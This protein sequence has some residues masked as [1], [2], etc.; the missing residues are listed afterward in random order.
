MQRLA[1][2]PSEKPGSKCQLGEKHTFPQPANLLFKGSSRLCEHARVPHERASTDHSLV[3]VSVQTGEN[4][5][6]EVISENTGFYD[7]SIHRHT[8]RSVTHETSPVLA[9]AT[10]TT[11]CLEPRAHV[12]YDDS[13]LPG[14]SSTMDNAGLLPTGCYAGSNFQ[15]ESGDHRCIQH[16]LRCNVQWTP[17]FQHL[18][19]CEKSV[20]HKLPRTT[21]CL[22]SIE[23]FSFRHCES[24]RSDLFGQHNS[25]GVHKSPLMEQASSPLTACDTCPRLPELRSGS[26]VTPRS[27]T[28]GMEISSADSD[29]DLGSIRQS[30]SQS[31]RHRGER[32]LSPLVLHVPSPTGRGGETQVCISLGA[33]PSFCHQQSPSG[34]GNSSVN[35]AKMAHSFLVS[36]DDRNTRWPTM[37]NIA[38]ERLPLSSK[39]HNL[40]SSARAVEPTHV[41]PE[42]STSDEPEL[43]QL[44]MNTILKAKALSTR[45]LNALKWHV[46][47]NWCSS[48][49]KDPVNC[50]IAEILTFLR[51]RLD[52]G[53][54][55]STL[56]VYV[57]T[58]SA[59]HTPE[60]GSLIGTH[61]LVI[62]FLWGARHLNPLALLW[63]QLGT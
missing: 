13:L 11:M 37:G 50:S 40:A 45:C 23:S 43:A 21:G 41:A 54:T 39:R 30:G 33:P 52:A 42:W 5:A 22:S 4:I 27:I 16:R 2:L 36:G 20:A 35:C 55:P 48:H 57:A 60:A 49:G 10:C 53:L 58:L 56:K 38:E 63:C 28:R 6:T 24:P 46:F 31:I 51:E 17:D 18:D 34:Q 14:C 59:Y 61:E 32:P 1:A 62:K 25:S 8:V 12:H 19:R 15:K 3:F 7:C 9:Q 29:E 47:G 26:V 44:V